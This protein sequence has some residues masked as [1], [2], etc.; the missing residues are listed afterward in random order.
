MVY[1]HK[2]ISAASDI[3]SWIGA[4]SGLFCF[5]YCV[6]AE[7]GSWGF[8][9]DN[10]FGIFYGFF[11][12]IL[13]DYGLFSGF[14]PL[15]DG[16]FS[17]GPAQQKSRAKNPLFYQVWLP[18]YIIKPLWADGIKQLY[19][20]D[21]FKSSYPNSSKFHFY[22]CKLLGNEHQHLKMFCFSWTFQSCLPCTYLSCLSTVYP[23]CANCRCWP[24]KYNP[25]PL[26]YNPQ[27]L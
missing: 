25:H 17:L 24:L 14:N 18:L 7:A 9:R 6:E 27:N 19:P 13:C 20:M 22:R 26:E 11:S 23:L 2:E 15:P 1:D 21:K 16:S 12:G 4:W 5:R 10:F 3:D 8:S